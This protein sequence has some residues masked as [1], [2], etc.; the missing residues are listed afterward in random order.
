MRL[1]PFLC[2]LLAGGLSVGASAA[3]AEAPPRQE[4][5]SSAALEAAD[6]LLTAMGYDAM[7]KHAVDA[8]IAKMAPVL[9]SSMEK[10]TGQPIDDALIARLT[11]IQSD[12]LQQRLV[13]SAD[14]RR[15]SALVY[16]NHFTAGEL[17]HLAQLYKDP[18]MRK[19]SQVGPDAAAEIMPLVHQVLE[20]HQDELEAKIKAAVTDYYAGKKQRPDI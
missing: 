14:L 10:E 4:K 9:K 11:A 5:V 2:A 3:P 18:V 19:W 17:D 12:F 7:M 1:R 13:K 6:R 16:A 15:A 20:T 8:M